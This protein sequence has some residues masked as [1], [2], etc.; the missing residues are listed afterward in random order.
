M[1]TETTKRTLAQAEAEIDRLNG[2]LDEAS[3]RIRART[4][5]GI[6]NHIRSLLSVRL[7]ECHECDGI[8][9]TK[10]ERYVRECVACKGTGLTS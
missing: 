6:V 5:N 8:G 2:L 4:I 7:G 3:R 10:N 1:T 9:I